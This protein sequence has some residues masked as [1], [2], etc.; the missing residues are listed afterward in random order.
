MITLEATHHSDQS[1]QGSERATRLLFNSYTPLLVKEKSHLRAEKRHSVQIFM[2]D[3]KI[4]RRVTTV[5][6]PL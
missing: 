2:K 4:F 6:K 5:G 1:Q 3:L